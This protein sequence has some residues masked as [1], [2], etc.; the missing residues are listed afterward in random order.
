MGPTTALRLR[1]LEMST[2]DTSREAY[3]KVIATLQE[4]EQEVCLYLL[5]TGEPCTT[6]E[7]AAGVD[8]PRDS[9]SPRMIKL[10]K[11]GV[12]KECGERKCRILTTSTM[13]TWDLT[14]ELPKEIDKSKER[15]R[16]GCPTKGAI[17]SMLDAVNIQYGDAVDPQR[18]LALFTKRRTL[19]WTL[20]RLDDLLGESTK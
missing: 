10:K 6:R 7:I 17:E 14:F 3:R 16:S 5:K 8:R 9:I 12:V 1:G 4:R 19:Q 18:C 13:V 11:Q 2:V 20:G 15:T